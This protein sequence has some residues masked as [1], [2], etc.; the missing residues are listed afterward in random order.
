VAD[1][2]EVKGVEALLFERSE[3]DNLLVRMRFIIMMIRKRVRYHRTPFWRRI[4]A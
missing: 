4:S 2:E 3:R 1:G